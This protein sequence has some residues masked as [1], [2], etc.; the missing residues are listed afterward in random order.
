M[1]PINLADFQIRTRLRI[2]LVQTRRQASQGAFFN[3]RLFH[4][5]SGDPSASPEAATQDEI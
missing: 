2:L 3:D 5:A 4:E 1:N